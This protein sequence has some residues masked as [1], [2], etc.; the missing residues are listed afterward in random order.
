MMHDLTARHRDSD[1]KDVH[2]GRVAGRAVVVHRA[3]YRLIPAAISISSAS[4]SRH[5]H[6][7][8]IAAGR[9][10]AV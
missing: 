1:K 4:S 3:Y 10:A 7:G 5:H 6:L 9:S 8:S 2:H